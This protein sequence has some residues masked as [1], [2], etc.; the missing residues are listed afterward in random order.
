MAIQSYKDLK[1]YSLSYSLAMEVFNISISF[2][3]EEMYSL[4]AQIRDSSRSVPSNL[5]EGWAKRRYANVFK[6]HIID[7]I[8]SACETKDWLDFAL[9]SKYIKSDIHS[10]LFNNY[11]EVGK[12]LNGLLENWKTF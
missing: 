6:R 11:E 7:A 3:K 2:P 10:N 9:D 12:M 4:T 1:V 5:A 8:G